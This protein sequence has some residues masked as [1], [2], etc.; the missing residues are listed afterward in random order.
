MYKRQPSGSFGFA[1]VSAES[2]LF[3]GEVSLSPVD[4]FYASNPTGFVDLD[5]DKPSPVS[6]VY[7]GDQIVY[8]ATGGNYS[9]IG[10]ESGRVEQVLRSNVARLIV[11]DVSDPVR[12]EII[13][14][15]FQE[16]PRPY[17]IDIDGGLAPD[18]FVV[19]KG[20]GDNLFAA[21]ENSI[22]HFD[23]TLPADPVLLNVEQTLGTVR[24]I[25]ID[26]RLLYVSD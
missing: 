5:D 7:L 15:E 20:F 23:I 11:A 22:Y 12:P 19:L 21:G 2:E 16:I 13:E 26:G 6:T 1:Q 10:A 4:Y 18:G 24:D 25:L 9:V 14:R 8:A 3:A 17:H